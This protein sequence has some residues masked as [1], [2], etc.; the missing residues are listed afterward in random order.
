[1]GSIARMVRNAS[2]DACR[3]QS[4]ENIYRADEDDGLDVPSQERTPE[5][6]AQACDTLRS[7]GCPSAIGQTLVHFRVRDAQQHCS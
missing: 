3:R 5:A 6:R 1:M 2:S 7:R 4:L